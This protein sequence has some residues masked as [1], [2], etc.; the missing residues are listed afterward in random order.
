MRGSL[1]AIVVILLASC[2]AA[3][4]PTL[5][6][7]PPEVAGPPSPPPVRHATMPVPPRPP[8]DDAA[9]KGGPQA[10]SASEDQLK[11]REDHPQT[12]ATLSAHDIITAADQAR[13]DALG[14]IVWSKSLPDNITH[15]SELTDKLTNAVKQMEDHATA[16]GS[17]VATDVIA[18]RA[19]LYDLRIYLRTKGD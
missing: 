3:E 13:T 4:A 12:V 17:Y 1:S 11:A 5:P 10:T 2:S 9:P 6:L 8:H 15:M 16:P 7:P 19:A 18:A 14:Y